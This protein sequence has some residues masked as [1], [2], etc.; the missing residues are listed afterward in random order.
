MRVGHTST[1][2]QCSPSQACS[3]RNG[4]PHRARAPQRR[5]S[6]R[7]AAAAAAALGGAPACGPRPEGVEAGGQASVLRSPLA[8]PRHG[9]RRQ[10]GQVAC[11]AA[12]TSQAVGVAA[13]LQSRMRACVRMSLARVRCACVARL[14]AQCACTPTYTWDNCW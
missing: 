9:R 12:A 11:Q 5:S 7:T 2:G 6:T 14:L 4:P 1:G 8:Q 10:L 13:G 3:G